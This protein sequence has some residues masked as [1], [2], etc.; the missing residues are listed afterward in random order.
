MPTTQP[1]TETTTGRDD[2]RLTAVGLLFE[3]ANAM[4]R[5][6]APDL[7]AA[8]LAGS[9]FE[10]LIRLGRTEGASLRMADLARQAGLS[11]SGATRLVDRL[12]ARGLVERRACESDGRVSYAVLTDA[13]RG[14]VAEVLPVH[15]AT[16]ER[17]YT[18]VLAPEQLE[19][20]N[21]ALRAVR[22][23]VHPDAEQGAS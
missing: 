2:P 13:G 1:T 16:I 22:A 14:V 18:G 7:A 19:Q 5:R 3:V 10:V 20:L 4:E 15:V 8:G 21:D 17:W 11:A 23:E 9:E 6:L 12:Q